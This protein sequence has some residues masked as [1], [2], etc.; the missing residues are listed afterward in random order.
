[1]HYHNLNIHLKEAYVS[2]NFLNSDMSNCQ[3]EILH[4]HI[5]AHGPHRSPDQ[6]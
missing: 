5:R 6:Q 1:M 2:A 4:F 3:H